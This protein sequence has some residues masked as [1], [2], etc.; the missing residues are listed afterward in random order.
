MIYHTYPPHRG[1]KHH[2]KHHTKEKRHHH[3]HTMHHQ[4]H[5]TH[6]VSRRSKEHATEKKGRVSQFKLS[7]EIVVDLL[8]GRRIIQVTEDERE[9][10]RKGPTVREAN[11]PP[12]ENAES[13][14]KAERTKKRG[15][16]VWGE[17]QCHRAAGERWYHN[18]AGILGGPRHH[19]AFVSLTSTSLLSRYSSR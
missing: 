16:R 9:R 3:H 2:A 11:G 15:S 7:L 12:D 6:V 8:D 5:R 19:W 4:H 14:I 18:A 10:E 13:R 1:S 17:S